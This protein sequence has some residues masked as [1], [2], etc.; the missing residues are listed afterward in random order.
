MLPTRRSLAAV[1]AAGFALVLFAC[2]DAIAPRRKPSA[3]TISAATPGNANASI[4]FTAPTDPG[5][6]D[7]TEYK[8]TCTA[9]G[10][11]KSATGAESPIAV[12]GLTNGTEYSCIVVATSK[13][14]SSEASGSVT[15]TPFTVPTAPLIG[16]GT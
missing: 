1:A 8:A 7:I 14:G 10:V 9:G 4:V 16:T 3:P 13:V 5:T 2:N 6:S 12:T 11:S 15:V